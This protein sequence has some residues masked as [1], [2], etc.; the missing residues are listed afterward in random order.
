MWG[1]LKRL[2]VV[3]LKKKIPFDLTPITAVLPSLSIH[4]PTTT[5]LWVLS[6]KAFFFFPRRRR[7]LL[8]Q[9]EEAIPLPKFAQK[10]LR[11]WTKPGKFPLYVIVNDYHTTCFKKSAILR[12]VHLVVKGFTWHE[13]GVILSSQSYFVIVVFT[14]CFLTQVHI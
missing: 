3:F 11:N 7:R 8:I 5:H 13:T 9:F 1:G 6:E 12:V 10:V 4:L 14:Y 2:E